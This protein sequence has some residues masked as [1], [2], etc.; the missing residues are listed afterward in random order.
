MI[1]RGMFIPFFGFVEI[2]ELSSV[3]GRVPWS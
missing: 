3:L 1:G 2:G